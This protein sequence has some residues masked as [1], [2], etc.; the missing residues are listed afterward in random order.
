MVLKEIE[1]ICVQTASPISLWGGPEEQSPA[2]FFL[3]GAGQPHL[4]T[5]YSV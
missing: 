3:G 2:D 1:L 5:Y 4:M